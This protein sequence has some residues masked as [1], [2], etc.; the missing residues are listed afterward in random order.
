[1]TIIKDEAGQGSNDD[2]GIT[3]QENTTPRIPSTRQAKNQ[4]VRHRASVAC[5]SCRDRRIRCVV[6]KGESECVQCKK[7]GNECVIK[8]D[9]E[10]RRYVYLRAEFSQLNSGLSKMLTKSPD[11]YQRRTCR[12]C[13]I[14]LRCLRACCRRRVFNLHQPC[15]P[16][17]RDTR[18]SSYRKSQESK[19]G[20][21]SRDQLPPRSPRLRIPET[22]TTQ[23][24]A[25]TTQ[26]TRPPRAPA[27]MF[28]QKNNLHSVYWIQHK[29]TLS[30]GFYRREG[31]FHLT[32]YLD[33]SAS[34]ARRPILM[35]TTPTL[36][37][38]RG[39]VN[40]QSRYGVL[41]ALF[42]H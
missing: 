21:Q 40:H 11:Q 29:R 39:L 20:F 2:A 18:P 38:A 22:M 17:R 36:V 31:I 6:P 41:N 23:Y 5:A 25:A 7:A 14:A 24:K 12:L 15:I 35:F 26:R 4:Q 13:P 33:G 27:S 28:M 30:T 37:I 1:M 8:N 16:R 42:G 9:D 3:A 10:R 34:S 32:S 19:G